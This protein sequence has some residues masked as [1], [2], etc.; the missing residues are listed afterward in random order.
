M[1]G[2]SDQFLARTRITQN[3]HGGVAGCDRPGLSQHAL[4]RR[5]LAYDFFEIEFAAEVGGSRRITPNSLKALTGK[6]L[7]R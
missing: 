7:G 1:D 2:A 3:E 4:E 6:G 5:T